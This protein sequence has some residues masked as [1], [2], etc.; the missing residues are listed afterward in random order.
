MIKN[1]LKNYSLYL[2]ISRKTP[3]F[4]KKKR[5]KNFYKCKINLLQI[6]RCGIKNR[7]K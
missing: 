4:K 3:F 5:K 2:L 7:D 1:N 6:T